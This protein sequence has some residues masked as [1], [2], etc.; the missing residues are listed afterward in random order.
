MTMER[1]RRGAM[2][3]VLALST[4]VVAEACGRRDVPG[5][6]AEAQGVP[7]DPALMAFL[8]R[9]RAAHHLADLREES[10]PQVAIQ[11]LVSATDGPL[12][13]PPGSPPAEA[14]EVIADAAARIAEL[15][16]RLGQFDA[17]LA[18]LDAGLRW[19]PEVSYFRGRLFET[20]G[21][22]EQR[23]AEEL[24]KHGNDAAA[25][26]ARAKAIAAFEASMQIQADVIRRTPAETSLKPTAEATARQ[27]SNDVV[28]PEPSTT[29][30]TDR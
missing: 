22:V 17:A 3:L 13:G 4:A 14:R 11:S 20:R 10:E 1:T 5:S 12:P 30:G 21:I 26:I 2:L 7:I 25:D 23:R 6:D 15:Q 8:S 24:R 16:S 9:A 19:V 29:R 28:A 27:L 18:R